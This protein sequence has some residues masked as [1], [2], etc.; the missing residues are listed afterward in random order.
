MRYYLAH[1]GGIEHDSDYSNQYII[2]RY[3]KGLQNGMGNLT[4]RITRGKKW[5]VRGAVEWAHRNIVHNA[6]DEDLAGHHRQLLISLRDEVNGKMDSLD[7]RAALHTIMDAIY[8]ANRYLQHSAPWSLATKASGIPDD[9]THYPPP[10]SHL[11]RQRKGEISRETAQA[12][13]HTCVF[14]C[15]E[16]LRICGILLQP[17]MP[18]KAA[19]L[20]DM[21]GVDGGRRTFDDAVYGADADYGTSKIELGRGGPGGTLF[22][23]LDSDT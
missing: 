22:P 4:S 23:P 15:A 19:K 2:E 6:P 9:P 10:R 21:L 16:T 18:E 13:V 17:Y 14:L 7:S 3:L 11:E 8:E 20:L 12:H 5:S 1:D